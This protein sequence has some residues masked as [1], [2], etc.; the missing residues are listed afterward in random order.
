MPPQFNIQLDKYWQKSATTIKKLVVISGQMSRTLVLPDKY[1]GRTRILSILVTVS[2]SALSAFEIC[3]DHLELQIDPQWVEHH[4]EAAQCQRLRRGCQHICFFLILFQVS[5]LC[6]KYFMK[7]HRLS[8]Q[9]LTGKERMRAGREKLKLQVLASPVFTMQRTGWTVHSS[10]LVLCGLR[11][12]FT[13]DVI[14]RGQATTI[15]L[16]IGPFLAW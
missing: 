13:L 1:S 12:G 6:F 3:D 11:K 15:F 7:E 4:L 8:T 14:S 5:Y 9:L 2:Q 16:C 10:F